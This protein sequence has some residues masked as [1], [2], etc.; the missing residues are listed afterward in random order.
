[1][2]D[3]IYTEGSPGGTNRTAVYGRKLQER[4]FLLYE[5]H[6]ANGEVSRAHMPFMTNISISESGKANL[7]AY[8]LLGRAGQLFSYGGSDSRSLDLSFEINFLHLMHLQNT[9]GFTDRMTRVIKNTDRRTEIRRFTSPDNAGPV[10][11]EK[12]GAKLTAQFLELFGEATK[13]E[14]NSRRNTT[15]RYGSRETSIYGNSPEVQKSIDLAMYWINL[16]RASVLNNSTNTVYGPPIVRLNHGPMYMNSPCLVEDY[17]I[18]IDKV[19]NYD[20]ETLFPYTIKVNMNLIE[21]RTGD[22]GD[23]EKGKTVEGDNLTGWESIISENVLDAMNYNFED[24]GDPNGLTKPITPDP[25]GTRFG[26]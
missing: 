9:E 26:N 16:I 11:V 15:E 10:G 6:G 22:F 23:Y 1:M 24:Y 20:V 14:L 19:S 3:T 25:D 2:S 5:F 17:K 4:S 18:S 13:R 7:A 12:Y 21:S 8:N